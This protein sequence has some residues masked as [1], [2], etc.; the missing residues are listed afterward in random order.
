MAIGGWAQD[1]LAAEDVD[2]SHRILKACGGSIAYA[3]RAVVFHRHRA[4]DEQLRNQAHTY[5]SG[6]ALI[7]RRYPDVVRWDARK[8]MVLAGRLTARTL[9]PPVLRVGSALGLA[10]P[11]RAEYARYDRLWSWAFWRGFAASYRR[12]GREWK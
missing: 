12:A 10:R 4:T 1:L 9:L 11:E 5:G 6:V 3:P 7:Y 8:S 2:F